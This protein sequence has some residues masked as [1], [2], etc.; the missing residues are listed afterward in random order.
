MKKTWAERKR[1]PIAAALRS[2]KHG[3]SA[4]KVFIPKG[5]TPEELALPEKRLDRCMA[6]DRFLTFFQMDGKT[7]CLFRGTVLRPGSCS[8]TVMVDSDVKRRQM[9]VHRGGKDEQ[10]V[11]FD[12]SARPIHWA[13]EVP[14]RVI[15]KVALSDYWRSMNNLPPLNG[16]AK[17]KSKPKVQQGDE[18]MPDYM[19]RA[20]KLAEELEG[21]EPETAEVE[22]ADKTAS[23]KKVKTVAKTGKKSAATKAGHNGAAK[24]KTG[25]HA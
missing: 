16:E 8:V 25:G 11:E 15:G 4:A 10:L 21:N 12:G 5:V 14:V 6:G 24:R 9:T 20:K 23:K 18:D 2:V 13:G 3:H 17:T 19:K 22:T 7:H 1:A